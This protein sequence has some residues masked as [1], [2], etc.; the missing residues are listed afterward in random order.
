L[1]VGIEV[2]SFKRSSGREGPARSALSL[3][4]DGGNSSLLSPIDGVSLGFVSHNMNVVGGFFLGKS[5]VDFGKFLIIHVH[6]FVG[7]NGESFSSGGEFFVVVVDEN[8]VGFVD[9]ES[10]CVFVRSVGSSVFFFE[11]VPGIKKS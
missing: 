6:E 1:F 8:N 9:L 2:G 7:S 4:L 5:K 10:Q 3:V 11:V